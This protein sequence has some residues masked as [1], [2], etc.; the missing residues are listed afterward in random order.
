MRYNDGTREL[1][2]MKNDLGEF[3]NLVQTPEH[4]E[5]LKKLD[6]LLQTRLAKAGIR[7]SKKDTAKGKTKKQTQKSKPNSN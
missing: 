2:D 5:R 6:A 4:A 7:D 3:T 1:Y